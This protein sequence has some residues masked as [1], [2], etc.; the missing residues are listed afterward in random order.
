MPTAYTVAGAPMVFSSRM[1]SRI[2]RGLPSRIGFNIQK[3]RAPGKNFDAPRS[4]STDSECA[5]PCS[6]QASAPSS[7]FSTG[8]GN[9]GLAG[10]LRVGRAGTVTERSRDTAHW[11]SSWF[12]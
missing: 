4:V 3:L 9:A 2:P 11:G 5:S 6:T 7:Q 10:Q 12:L 1:I 8:D